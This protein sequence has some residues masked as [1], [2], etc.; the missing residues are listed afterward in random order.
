MAREIRKP[1]DTRR[2]ALPRQEK[3]RPAQ[4]DYP[5]EVRQALLRKLVSKLGKPGGRKQS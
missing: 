5:P 4:P 1:G 3:L 2:S